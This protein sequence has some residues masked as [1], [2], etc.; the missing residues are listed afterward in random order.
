MAYSSRLKPREIAVD[1]IKA[2]VGAAVITYA[3]LMVYLANGTID[4]W[5]LT[6]FWTAA[7]PIFALMIAC[8]IQDPD[9]VFLL[10]G[11]MIWFSL[12]VW[13]SQRRRKAR[14]VGPI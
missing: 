13:Y 5:I 9:P 8:G 12:I 2:A 14:E 10:A 1:V 3:G 7:I 11:S 4:S 6:P